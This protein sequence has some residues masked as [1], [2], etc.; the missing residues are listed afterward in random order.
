MT[1]Q[2]SVV[3]EILCLKTRKEF[4]VAVMAGEFALS[5]LVRYKR[6]IFGVTGERGLAW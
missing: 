3:L 5:K 2:N 1:S 6:T 4:G